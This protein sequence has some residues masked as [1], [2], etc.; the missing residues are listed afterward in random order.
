MER[1]CITLLGT[2]S[3]QEYL[4]RSNRLKENLGASWIVASALADWRK[5]E[6]ALFVG[7]G[8]A[9]VEFADIQQARH[10]TEKWS[11][12]IV[13][14]YPGL[15]VTAWHE[16]I[17]SGEPLAD[18]YR[19]A[20]QELRKRESFPQS[21]SEMGALPVIRPCAST[22]LGASVLQDGRWLSAEALAK[23]KA[24]EQ[25]TERL[26]GVYAKALH[27]GR[28]RCAFPDDLGKL[29]Q[30]EDASQIAIVHADG[31][32]VG[33]LLRE[34]C[35]E[36]S[37]DAFRRRIRAASDAISRTAE[38]ALL[39]TLTELSLVLPDLEH[40]GIKL[41]EDE[42]KKDGAAAW[43][44]VRPIVEGGD[45]LTFVCH[46]RLGLA[47]AAR[48]LSN[49][50]RE[51][52]QHSDALNGRR[53]TACAG[54]LIMPQK[55]PFA[56]GY[57]LVERLTDNAKQYRYREKA[58]GS[59][60]DFQVLLEGSAG[61]LVAIRDGYPQGYEDVL[62]RPY[63]LGA[64]SRRGWS[65]FEERVRQF[66]DG[67]LWPRSRAKLLME[68]LVR[69]QDETQ[70]LLNQFKSRGITLPS[71]AWLSEPG[72]QAFYTP[73]FDPLELLDFHIPVSWPESGEPAHAPNN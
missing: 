31:N 53:L 18:A 51:S 69:G 52:L 67:K 6:G 36:T 46:G 17:R 73:Y 20:Q 19:R 62:C 1:R 65:G 58:E 32:G 10:A 11:F 49:F 57:R 24:A 14:R 40:K 35:Q 41:P 64:E 38:N 68:A 56:R 8:N 2:A 37:D 26:Q 44:P 4:F 3:I 47:L 21:G 59:W 45:D 33:E 9:A 27:V 29:G 25:A 7:G 30:S 54:V 16:E 34:V 13:S 61:S 28:R 39:Q 23:T 72:S 71:E 50:E 66:Q 70:Q 15:R 22:G 43:Y 5:H 60:L 48:Y 55:F 12:G 42:R 63:T